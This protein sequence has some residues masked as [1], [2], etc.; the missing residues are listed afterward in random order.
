MDSKR[1]ISHFD[2]LASVRAYI[3]RIGA[4]M[5]GKS[6]ADILVP[7]EGHYEKTVSSVR[8][9]RDGTVKVADVENTPTESEA[10][11]IKAELKSVTWPSSVVAS[12]NADLPAAAQKASP[13]DV[14]VCRDRTGGIAMVQIER[15]GEEKKPPLPFTLMDDGEWHCCM[16]DDLVP[17]YGFETIG[18]NSVVF[19]HE[20]PR[21]ARA[22]WKLANPV[23]RE[24]KLASADHPWAAEM[25]YA[26]H[27]S[28]LNGAHGAALVDW[29][30]LFKGTSVRKIYIMCDHDTAGLAPV[31][32]IAFGSELSCYFLQ[33][34]SQVFDDETVNFPTG[35]DICNPLP[36]GFYG[37]LKSGKGY[38]RGPLLMDLMRCCTSVDVE[39]YE[40][41]DKGEI[42][43]VFYIPNPAFT[44]DWA[45]I[46]DQGVIVNKTLP[47]S[48]YSL[49]RF[50]ATFRR[51]SRGPKSKTSISDAVTKAQTVFYD[52][53]DYVPMRRGNLSRLVDGKFNMFQPSKI[54]A[55]AGDVTPWLDFLEHL[56]PNESDRK[57]VSKWLA[58]LIACPETRM[59]FGLVLS[60]EQTGIGKGVLTERILRPILGASNCTSV[61][62]TAMANDTFNGWA[63]RKRLAV[64]P[65]LYAAGSTKLAN[66]LKPVL[67][68]PTLT[69]NEKFL[70]PYELRNYLHMIICSNDD[71]P[72]RIDN[73]D[74]RFFVPEMGD[75]K[76]AEPK[77]FIEWLS[78][79]G[80][81]R[82]QFW[83]EQYGDYFRDAEPAPISQ[84]KMKLIEDSR[85]P[86][87]R[88]AFDLAQT[89]SASEACLAIGQQTLNEWIRSR[90]GGVKILAKNTEIR[91]AAKEGG[92]IHLPER[93]KMNGNNQD[94]LVTPALAEVLSKLTI[95]SSEYNKTV[96]ANTFNPHTYL[97]ATL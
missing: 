17:V 38:Y 51:F 85:L 6:R 90:L 24:E 54:V 49:S 57:I 26:G 13:E 95:N 2:E 97:T 48:L 21:K 55:E 73:S 77:V 42:V 81:S 67:T 79:V 7:G 29:K 83:A 89:V 11:A 61:L 68:E 31:R 44:A 58:T 87:Q 1:K 84:R 62:E 3:E 10:E 78:T 41:N 20:G 30:A 74:R 65:E 50:D 88:E 45:Y 82:I 56:I 5:V 72:L 36:T 91:K 80:L 63:A 86:E 66:R 28:F 27:I 53:L 46:D 64:V 34:S 15:R 25:Q 19:I 35:W 76:L 33:F 9:K 47:K 32:D 40:R 16:P 22:A 23:T 8:F 70:T 43:D 93:I 92:M 60:S 59:Y 37:K 12:K 75:T 94:I 4:K 39:C 52:D 71:V 14:Y 96:R 18:D 69:I